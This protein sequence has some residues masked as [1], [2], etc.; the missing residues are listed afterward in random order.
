MLLFL[1]CFFKYITETDTDVILGWREFGISYSKRY[2]N[3]SVH[4]APGGAEDTRWDTYSAEDNRVLGG[5]IANVLNRGFQTRTLP[6][7]G[8]GA[9][10][11]WR[12]L[13]NVS[14]FCCMCEPLET[15]QSLGDDTHA[16]V[17]RPRWA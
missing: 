13:G 4:V 2:S 16:V 14:T 12:R 1:V 5:I 7:N 3:N 9:P 11:M 10:Q 8:I 15:A 17:T 6:D